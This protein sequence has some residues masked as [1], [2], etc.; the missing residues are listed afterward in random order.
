MGSSGTLP[1]G[2]EPHY[3]VSRTDAGRSVAVKVCPRRTK[4]DHDGRP[5]AMIHGDVVE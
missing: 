2:Y 1:K 5:D 4:V 3:A